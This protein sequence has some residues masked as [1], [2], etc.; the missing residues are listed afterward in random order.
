MM[1]TRVK[2]VILTSSCF[3]LIII[4]TLAWIFGYT[5]VFSLERHVISAYPV[6]NASLREI[7]SHFKNELANQ[8][9]NVEIRVLDETGYD[10]ARFVRGIA[11]NGYLFLYSVSDVFDTDIRWPRNGV[12]IVSGVGSKASKRCYPAAK[13][14]QAAGTT[15][16]N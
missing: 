16:A 8:G 1:S 6:K 2:T 10:E 9:M 15:A 12:I 13:G 11:G 4:A 14:V 3:F 7:M 5:M